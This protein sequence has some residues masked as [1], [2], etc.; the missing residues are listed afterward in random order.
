MEIQRIP[1]F[2]D[3][4]VMCGVQNRFRWI[5]ELLVLPCLLCLSS[6]A[7]ADTPNNTWIVVA[8]QPGTFDDS[9][10][11]GNARNT[12]CLNKPAV[13]GFAD[14]KTTAA[15]F[16]EPG[17]IAIDDA[18]DLYVL[19]QGDSVVRKIMPDG[20]TVTLAKLE[21]ARAQYFTS[22]GIAVDHSGNTFVSEVSTN[23]I[24]KIRLDGSS[25]VYAG[26]PNR[27]GYRNGPAAAS[28]F[29]SPKGLAV[30]Q[31]GNLYVA[32]SA[33]NAVRK[34]SRDGVV[35]TVAGGHRGMADGPA[36]S[37]RF[38]NPST[39]VLDKAGNIFVAEFVDVEDEGRS[40]TATA[41][42]KIGI[43]GN[44]ITLGEN[45]YADARTGRAAPAKKP[46]D[47]LTVEPYTAIAVDTQGFMYSFAGFTSGIERTSLSGPRSEGTDTELR[48]SAGHGFPGP[49]HIVGVVVD[50]HGD[51]YV[52][53][54]TDATI[55]KASPPFGSW[56]DRPS[57]AIHGTGASVED[58]MLRF[59]MPDGS[60]SKAFKVE[61]RRFPG[62]PRGVWLAPEDSMMFVL[63]PD[64]SV[65]G[66]KVPDFVRFRATLPYP[67][68]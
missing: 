21:T 56:P 5:F 14:G 45:A 32:D 7:A 31:A 55:W 53:D 41:I 68:P 38:E 20:T 9:D 64:R 13:A 39:L 63:D 65:A 35:T 37:A 27:S 54:S 17:N 46:D 58:G 49:Q 29:S 1:C 50:D 51:V 24:L 22:A 66:I 10:A 60:Q 40:D 34:I 44:V 18:G 8:G 28:L 2:P 48:I 47:F 59:T 4:E 36:L 11:C 33:N 30:D 57:D 6:A 15:L 3:F 62:D 25:S 19:D 67:Q 23:I 43:D 61:H 16:S 42:R 12:T 52:S 26:V